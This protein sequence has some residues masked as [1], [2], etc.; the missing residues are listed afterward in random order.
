MQVLEFQTPHYKSL[1]Y[2]HICLIPYKAMNLIY[3]FDLQY[4]CCKKKKDLNLKD[5]YLTFFHCH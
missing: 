5:Y 1:K 4:N 3:T 2:L